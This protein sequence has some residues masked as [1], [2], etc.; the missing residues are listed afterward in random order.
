MFRQPLHTLLLVLLIAAASFGLVTRS[1]EYI[2]IRDRI[3]L[4]SGFF[5]NVG[6]LSHRD[7]ITADASEAIA[8]LANH[9]DV[10]FYDRRRGF[11]GTLVDMHN[12]YVEGSLYWLASW[13]YRYFPDLFD[14]SEY[15]ALLPRLRPVDGF[16]GFG[17]GDS[18]FYGTV[19]NVSRVT[20]A[21][22]RDAW[23]GFYPHKVLYVEVDKVVQGYPTRLYEGQTLRLRMDFPEGWEDSPLEG[24][25]VGQ[26]YFF[27]GTFYYM[28]GRL[29]LDSRTITKFIKPIG[30][31]DP[32][33]YVAV[34]E[35][36]E[37]DTAALGLCQQLKFARHVQSAVYLRTTRDMSA[38]PYA[39]DYLDKVTL[40]DGRFINYED[41]LEARPVVVIQRRFAER[42]RIRIG[43]TITVNVNAD[44]HLIYYP[45]YIVGNPDGIPTPQR[46]M[47][48]PELGILSVPGSYPYVTLEL[49][50]V[51]IFDLFRRRL[52]STHWSS[53]NKFMFVPDSVIPAD[54]GLQSAHFGEIGDNYVPALWSSFI[55]NDPRN[56]L[57]FLWDT[58]ESLAEMGFRADFLGRDGSGFWN[59]TDVIMMSTTLNLLIF[60]VVTALVLALAAFLYLKQRSKE[61]IIQRSLG[62]SCTRVI[63]Q[64]MIAITLFGL[65]AIIGGAIV[66]WYFS[67]R[68]IEDTVA[69]FGEIIA[70]TI[71]RHF[72]PSEREAILEYYTQGVM[73]H[74]NW[75]IA[76]CVII[77]ASMLIFVFFG[78]LI[79]SN[80]SVLRMLQSG[81]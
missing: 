20:H 77:F 26:R 18:F 74:V 5:H 45:Y 79:M 80:K 4:I 67:S 73:P 81:R 35:G 33:W 59:A 51:G 38:M 42:Q 47:I 36:D 53:L 22:G 16:A 70:S 21:T 43:D 48:Y 46:V 76:F 28:L 75:L 72:L 71:G 58:R 44:Q 55:L 27:I 50:V 40:W 29:Q 54:W 64:S 34:E 24:I 25:E 63:A 65:P 6:V 66:G 15:I 19:T 2:A 30:E 32:I 31:V 49:E 17:S 12:F 60:S 78:N 39:Q 41:Y 3:H 62:C 7:G 68:L 11:E 23:W 56:Q 10:V 14:A 1:V 61:F 69:G 9:P 13:A 37:I 52:V 57:D 8:Y